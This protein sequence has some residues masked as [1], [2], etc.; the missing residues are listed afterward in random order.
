[1]VRYRLFGFA[2]GLSQLLF[3]VLLPLWLRLLSYL[4]P[5]VLAVVWMCLTVFVVFVVYYL[6][7]ET[8]NMPK[9]VIKILLSSYSV[10]LLILLFFRPMHQVYNQIN[11]IPFKTILA[12]LSGNGN[13]L[14]AFYNIA[15]NILLF[16]PYGVAALMFYRNP[17]KW[18]L[19]IV[20]V[21]I[22][23]LIETTQYLTKRGTMDIDDLILNLLGIWIGYLLYPVIQKVVRVK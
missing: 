9:R 8:V 16:I 21:V 18:Q 6:C 19:G 7:K 22:I 20:P 2:F 23:L 12:F 5:V 14:V 11:Y 1:M 3:L 17:S 10:G 13:M 15:A 4:N